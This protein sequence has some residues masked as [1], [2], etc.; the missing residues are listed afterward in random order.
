[1]ARRALHV[2]FTPKDN[3]QLPDVVSE[4][5]ALLVTLAQ[6]GL[7]ESIA[8]KVRIRRQGG[9]PGIDVVLVLL[10]YF[11]SGQKVGMRTLWKRLYPF[12]KRLAALAGRKSL[13]SPSSVQRALDAVTDEL[14]RPVAPWLLSEGADVDVVLRH[15]CVTTFDR[16]GLPWHVFDFDPTVTVLRHRALPGGPELP[17]PLRRSED[18]A[19]PGYQGQKRGDVMISRATLQH[20]GSSCWLWA[21]LSPGNGEP[22]AS[23]Q[24]ALDVVVLTC[25]RL[26]HPL[27]RALFRMD[28]AFGSVPYYS[29]CRERGVPFLT[30]LNR[31]KLFDQ[32]DVRRSLREGV[33]QQV[34]GSGSGPL[35]GALDLGLVTLGPSERTQRPDGREYEPLTVRVV[36][37]RYERQEEAE[38]GVLLEG[39]Q[40]ELFAID[41]PREAFSA[42]DAV[43][44]YF[45]RAGQE[46]RFAQE[47]REAGLDRIFSYHRPGQEMASL[48]GLWVWNLRVV[49]GF[50]MAPP[51]SEA[52]VA[53]LPAIWAD[54]RPA[55][56]PYAEG[57][58]APGPAL[59]PP[60]TVEETLNA[61]DWPSLLAQ[62][63]GWRWQASPAEL[64]C[65]QDRSLALVTVDL[66]QNER[67]RPAL[68]FTRPARGCEECPARA[69]CL[70]SAR[71]RAV[72]HIK[73]S[74]PLEPALWLRQQLRERRAEAEQR[75]VSKPAPK[76]RKRRL[77]EVAPVAG[78]CGPYAVRTSLFLPARARQLWR[79]A[80]RELTVRV[81][82]WE[83]APRQPHPLLLA[84]NEADRQHRRKTWRDNVE[85]Y[86]L[87]PEA[88]V[89]VV[90][91]GGRALLPHLQG[92][93]SHTT[94]ESRA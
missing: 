22:H 93:S 58:P 60:T 49:R 57:E 89:K 88:V 59:G 69:S 32:A 82:L 75:P 83:P 5:V 90:F 80:A 64:R 92:A 21:E 76:R 37:S 33:W 46:N 26:S 38:H 9:Y 28:G 35:R 30:R 62:R 68:I 77:F 91:A 18:L 42:A 85:R 47:D 4:G 94:V 71:R 2:T 11:A 79:E 54:T 25:Q 20:A 10:L 73:F 31:L 52:P 45:G 3:D 86:A 72:K 55:R 74:V 63:P 81:T 78:E 50:E 87:A 44:A 53:R 48:L 1:M 29:D 15:R 6:R 66:R 12:Q 84:L 7:I 43:A 19:L 16:L 61:L 41:A 27:S 70:P 51:P 36:V 24:A 34:P 17:A 14:L 8:H 67:G 39:W 40:Y 56:V 65:P 13:P 23:L